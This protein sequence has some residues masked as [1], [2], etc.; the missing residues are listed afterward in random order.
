MKNFAA[1]AL[2]ISTVLSLIIFNEITDP[3]FIPHQSGALEALQ[4]W[5]YE[6]AYPFEKI[7]EEKFYKAFEAKQKLKKQTN[8]KFE[9]NWKPIGPQNFGGRTIALA[10]NPLNPN[11]IYAGSAGG[12]L[13]VS[14]SAGVGAQAWKRIRTGFPILAVGAITIN[15][16]DTN[17]IFIGTGEVYN[18]GKTEGGVAVRETRGSYGMGILKTTDGGLTWS[19]SLDWSYEDSRGIMVL[20]F[21]PMNPNTIYAGTTE[22]VF[23]SFNSGQT[24]TNILDTLMTTDII[25]NSVDTNKIIAACGNMK[26]PGHGIYR[27]YNAGSEWEKLTSNLPSVYGGKVIFSAIPSDPNLIYASIGNG[28]WSGAGT[29]LCKTT[30]FG[31]SWTVVNTV[32]YATYQGWFAHIV[33]ANWNNPNIILVAGVDVYKSTNGGSSLSKKSN[34][35]A[36]YFGKPPLGGPEGPSN[37]S[38]A[39]HHTYAVH[40]TNP[41]IVYFGNDGGVFR[42][43]DFGETFEGLNGG[44]QTQQF[45]NGFTASLTDSNWA[46]G[47][48]QDNA[49]AIYDGE[50]AWYRAIGGDGSWAAID[51]QNNNIV[52]GSWQ[53]LN[54]Q[55]ST[56]R[57]VSWNYITPPSGGV[58]SFIA[59]YA[60][61]YDNP[62]IMYAARSIVYKSTNK[63]S[64]W[65]VT[66]NG[67]PISDNP[68]IAIDI[69]RNNSDYVYVATAPVNSR[70][71]IYRTKNGGIT[72]EDVTG[73]LPD[74]YPMDIRV[75]PTNEEM[76]IV[77][78]SGYGTSHVF[79]SYDAGVNW[80]DIS[81]G[82]PDVPVNAVAIHPLSSN[83]VFAGTDVGVFVSTNSGETWSVL[84]N[85]LPEGVIIKSLQIT[86]SSNTMKAATHGNGVYEIQLPDIAVSVN[87]N[88]SSPESFKLYQNYPNPFNPTT[89]IK[90]RISSLNDRPVFVELKVFDLLGKE[91]ATLIKEEKSPGEYAVVF[92]AQHL[93]SGI[94][95]YQLQAGNLLEQ[96]KML[97]LK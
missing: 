33:V 23:R 45:Y 49:T 79:K 16:I 34:W 41:N 82:L 19:K 94:Y 51:Q 4:Q 27:T 46:I 57:G 42:T 9:N 36:W 29:W 60:V 44:Y 80:I 38:H 35:A 30:D 31:D 63:G 48:M 65:K 62:D 47:G 66:N 55:K 74:R 76:V 91:I 73:N 89:T 95:I 24:W 71:G 43:T 1:L 67:D 13:W 59:P 52:Y 75:A 53:K 17:T 92:N 40:P 20:K 72:W 87:E 18:Y 54:I 50:L 21:N 84:S 25:I 64:S 68:P 32:D 28:Y 56:N 7:P 39:D 96:K 58:T 61:A 77:S 14:Y 15:P 85:G 26:S 22:G 69:A 83:T 86:E 3:H 10:I 37:Y 93:S 70:A 11:T 97:L 81:T 5:S 6:R 78:F 90:Y 88:I 8:I 12:G 2:V